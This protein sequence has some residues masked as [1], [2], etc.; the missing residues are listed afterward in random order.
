MILKSRVNERTKENIKNYKAKFYNEEDRVSTGFLIGLASEKIDEL[1]DEIL[2][3]ALQICAARKDDTTE[4]ASMSITLRQDVYDTILQFQKRLEELSCTETMHMAKVLDVL[5]TSVN[6]E[7]YQVGNHMGFI[8]MAEKMVNIGFDSLVF[9]NCYE[10]SMEQEKEQLLKYVR[11]YLETDSK[12]IEL[13]NNLRP[14]IASNIKSYSDY[15]NAYR[16][17]PTKRKS[18]GT[19]YISHIAKAVTGLL[20]C[21]AETEEIEISQI[22]NEMKRTNGDVC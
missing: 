8:E 17:N 15:F 11:C 18:L 14:K 19:A 1:T 20:L 13:C 2:E 3:N 4:N 21:I 5:M 10:I 16:Y 7:K 6:I 22:I 12:G 9:K